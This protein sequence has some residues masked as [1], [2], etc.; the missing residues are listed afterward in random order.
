MCIRDSDR[1]S[2]HILQDDGCPFHS[3]VVLVFDVPVEGLCKGL[4]MPEYAQYEKCCKSLH[5][6]KVSIR[7]AVAAFCLMSLPLASFLE[8][9]RMPVSYTHLD[10]YKRQKLRRVRVEG[11]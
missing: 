8:S 3:R 10:V 5:Y 7:H 11:S 4:E 1:L 9:T 6:F 2:L